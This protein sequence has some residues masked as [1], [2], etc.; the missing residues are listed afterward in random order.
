MA[1]Q[2]LAGL[3]VSIATLVWTIYNDQRSHT[4]DPEPDAIARQFRITA[5]K[6]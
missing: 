1:R 4:P 6:I 3:I 5:C 2:S